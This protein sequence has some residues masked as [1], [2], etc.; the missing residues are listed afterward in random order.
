M[1]NGVFRGVSAKQTAL[2]FISVVSVDDSH[3]KFVDLWKLKVW[4]EGV[5]YVQYR[6]CVIQ[7][8]SYSSCV[9]VVVPAE[10][11]CVFKSAIALYVNVI[12]TK[13][14]INPVIRSKPV[15]FVSRATLHV[16]ILF[17]SVLQFSTFETMDAN[18]RSTP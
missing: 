15:I 16:T 1:G 9:L 17:Y 8:D 14:L 18:L 7:W 13:V 11:Q 2:R 6:V 10:D 4:V 3:G 12:K 5:I